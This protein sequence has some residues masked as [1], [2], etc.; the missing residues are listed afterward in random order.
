[1]IGLLLLAGVMLSRDPGREA[2]PS[3]LI[4][5]PAPEFSL[6]VLHESGRAVS[7]HDLLGE[8]YLLNVWG[9]WCPECRVEHPVLTRFAETKQLR[10]IGFNLK[11]EPADALRWLAQFGNPYWLVLADY[12]GEVAID[13]G[14]YGAPET[15]LV[16]AG[17]IVRW[18][19]V[20]P[21]TD[22][23]VREQLLPALA[24]ARKAEPGR[25][26]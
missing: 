8:P 17:G 15:F 24:A 10:V 5:K 21:I 14:I 9:S 16:D 11:D 20:G 19:H 6:P 12:E 22:E 23:V 13:W 3:P 2:L 4:G 26:L 7:S 25:T 18:K 1:M